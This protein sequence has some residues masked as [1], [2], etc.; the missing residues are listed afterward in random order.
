MNENLAG[1][2]E[3]A[4]KTPQK[5]KFPQSEKRSEPGRSLL[6]PFYHGSLLTTTTSCSITT[7]TTKRKQ[8]ITLFLNPALITHARAQ[9]IVE[10]I[11]LTE[12]VEKALVQ[13]LP[14][15]IIIKKPEINL[16]K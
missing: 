11:N 3:G 8:R 4:I 2:F 14:E 16:K 12:L 6:T 5:S 13:Y 9:A 1:K 10:A 15:E 7:M